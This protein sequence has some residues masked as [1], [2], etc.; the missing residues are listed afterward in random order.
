MVSNKEI[1]EKLVT[2]PVLMNLWEVFRGKAIKFH[3][4]TG[5]R[6]AHTVVGINSQDG[7]LIITDDNGIK[8]IHSTDLIDEELTYGNGLYNYMS[9]DAN[10]E[11][12]ESNNTTDGN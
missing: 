5:D 10:F 4:R 12:I 8:C 11:V 6:Y 3:P 9:M 1:L 7:D 2:T